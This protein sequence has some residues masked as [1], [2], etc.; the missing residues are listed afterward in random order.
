MQCCGSEIFWEVHKAH[1]WR[2]SLIFIILPGKREK[3][4]FP[5]RLKT[6]TAFHVNV[7]NNFGFSLQFGLLMRICL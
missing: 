7:E 3:S 2:C 1:A 4:I 5:S 6:N